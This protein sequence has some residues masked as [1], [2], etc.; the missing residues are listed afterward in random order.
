MP[1]AGTPLAVGLALMAS[2]VAGAG[3]WNAIGEGSVT[4][5]GET[6]PWWVPER[7]TLGGGWQL[8]GSGVFRTLRVEAYPAPVGEAAMPKPRLLIEITAPQLR[9]SL[10]ELSWSP[11]ED[12]V[13]LAR[14]GEVEA[15]ETATGWAITF[16]AEVVPL[17]P[18]TFAPVAGG[19]PV[20]I[21]GTFELTAP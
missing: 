6:E 16:Q 20:K 11:A 17:D 7:E 4:I 10:T 3:E 5:D 18:A 19:M 21:G 1:R 14:G 12:V 15:R 2:G 8:E 9:P 13:H